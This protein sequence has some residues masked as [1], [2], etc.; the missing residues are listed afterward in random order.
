MTK[1][2]DYVNN[3]YIHIKNLIWRGVHMVYH[4]GKWISTYFGDGNKNT[5]QWFYPKE[6]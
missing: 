6:P 2:V 3:G 4:N 1:N 5:G